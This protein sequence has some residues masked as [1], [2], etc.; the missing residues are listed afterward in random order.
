MKRAKADAEQQS[1]LLKHF[2]WS[3]AIQCKCEERCIILPQNAPETYFGSW[4]PP[5]PAG[6]LATLPQP[7]HSWI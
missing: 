4:T 3:K 5:G 2:S 7:S 1:C 6:E